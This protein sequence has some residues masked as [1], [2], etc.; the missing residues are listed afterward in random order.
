M[1]EPLQGIGKFIHCFQP[2]L[3]LAKVNRKLDAEYSNVL[4]H[5]L[6]E[7]L[8]EVCVT[9]EYVCR[10][11]RDVCRARIK[12]LQKLVGPALV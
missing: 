11:L 6:R 9:L 2:V 4:I 5:S 7:L 8:R 3:P 10:V 1:H 12:L